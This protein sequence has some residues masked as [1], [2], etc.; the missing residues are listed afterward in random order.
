MGMKKICGNCGYSWYNSVPGA[1]AKAIL[2]VA[3]QIAVMRSRDGSYI[4]GARAGDDWRRCPNCGHP[5]YRIEWENS[6]E[7]QF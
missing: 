5:H 6:P 2:T 4:D 1:V 7:K 3:V